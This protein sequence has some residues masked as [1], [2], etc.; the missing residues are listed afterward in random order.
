MRPED[1][2]FIPKRENFILVSGEVYNQTAISFVPGKDAVWY[3]RQAGG[4]TPSGNKGAVF[5]I[6]ADGSVVGHAG[7]LLTGNAL[8]IRMRPGDSIIVPEK[9][10]GSQIWKNLIS[11]AQIMSSVAITGAVAGIF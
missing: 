4:A 7:S 1:T 9:T 10:V 6:R 3:L 8:N 11:V 5:V 2:L